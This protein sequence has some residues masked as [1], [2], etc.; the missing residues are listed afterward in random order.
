MHR[1][2]SRTIII[3]GPNHYTLKPFSFTDCNISWPD[4]DIYI[5]YSQILTDS[6]EWNA[7]NEFLLEHEL[8]LRVRRAA[9][10]HNDQSQAHASFRMIEV[11]KKNGILEFTLYLNFDDLNFVINATSSG[12]S[13]LF[14]LW[15]TQSH[16]YVCLWAGHLSH[17]SGI[18]NIFF[19]EF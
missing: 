7:A 18:A 1:I 15:H 8:A 6:F 14:G 4:V 5:L 16:S 3:G 12:I 2:A 17:F 10:D 13:K 9:A 19:L 11:K